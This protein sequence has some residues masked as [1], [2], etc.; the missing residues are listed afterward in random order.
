MPRASGRNIRAC[1]GSLTSSSSTDCASLSA[2]AIWTLRSSRSSETKN[3]LAELQQ[4]RTRPWPFSIHFIALKV[5]RPGSCALESASPETSNPGK[6]HNARWPALGASPF[7]LWPGNPRFHVAW[8]SR[9]RRPRHA[10]NRQRAG[11]RFGT[12]SRP[13]QILRKRRQRSRRGL[14]ITTRRHR[15][16]GSTTSHPW[17]GANSGPE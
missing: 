2:R 15:T 8:F 13:D 9:Q 4:P 1:R 16:H 17:P 14:S 6:D 7:G 5:D 3:V 10:E 12:L 11:L